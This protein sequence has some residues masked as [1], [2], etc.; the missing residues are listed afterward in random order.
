M[1]YAEEWR[2]MAP[3][4]TPL[5]AADEAQRRL[6]RLRSDGQAQPPPSPY[7][8]LDDE[9][10]PHPAPVIG[11]FRRLTECRRVSGLPVSGRLLGL[12]EAT[13]TGRGH[14]HRGRR[15]RYGRPG[16]ARGGMW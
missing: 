11:P 16:P 8:G 15:H 9:R 10:H 1:G 6:I 4:A 14:T 5:V 12:H 7:G 2:A 13:P 3:R